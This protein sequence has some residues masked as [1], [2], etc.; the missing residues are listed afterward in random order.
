MDND[1]IKDLVISP[2]DPSYYTAENKKSVWFYKNTGTNTNPHFVF[3]TNDF[4]QSE[5]LD[6]GTNSLPAVADMNGDGLYDLIIGNYGYYDSSHL[7]YGVLN[8]FY[9]SS[10]AYMKNNGTQSEPSF[11]LVTTDL[12][13]ASKLNVHGLTP[14]VYDL[15]NDGLPDLLCG[16]EDGSL[17]YFPCRGDSAGIPV[18]DPPQMNFQQIKT[19]GFS[20]PQLF[21][22]DRDGLPDLII[23]QQNG[24]MKYYRNIGSPGNPVFTFTLDSLGKV[25]VTNHNLSYYGYCTPFFFRNNQNKTCLLAGSDEGKLHLFSDIDGNISG[26]FLE[27]DSLNEYIGI[28]DDSLRI[29]WRTAGILSHFSDPRYFDLVCGNFSGGLNYFTKGKVPGI[30]EHRQDE[31][32]IGLRIYPNP[33]EQEIKIDL[34]KSGTLPRDCFSGSS[35]PCILR[36]YNTFGTEVKRMEYHPGTLISITNLPE[37]LYIAELTLPRSSQTARG[38]LLISRNVSK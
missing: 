7:E 19:G 13:G 18:F 31:S 15:N 1:G 6:F 2:F 26:R 5:M 27:I 36:L 34:M 33:A 9:T 21:D 35:D 20:A 23:G 32:I 37:G 4:F 30:Q 8:S 14:C 38:K 16:Q 22:L 12:A 29:G 25:D 24:T 17:I 28:P 10:I 3:Q 11:E